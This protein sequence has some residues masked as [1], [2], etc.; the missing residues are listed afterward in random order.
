MSVRNELTE[1]WK[2]SDIMTKNNVNLTSK[3]GRSKVA[4]MGA[5]ALMAVFLFNTVGCSSGSGQEEV[6][7]QLVEEIFERDLE[8]KIT[9]LEILNVEKDSARKN[10]YKGVAKVRDSAGDVF[11][12]D[13]SYRIVDDQVLVEVDFTTIIPL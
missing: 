9:C 1:V 7:Q 4:L 10:A 12:V 6:V 2:G 11:M 5:V 8:E 3:S 13:V